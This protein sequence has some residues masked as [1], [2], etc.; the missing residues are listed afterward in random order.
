MMIMW[1][2]N[3]Q[4]PIQMYP[5][6]LMPLM[7]CTAYSFLYALHIIPKNH[8]CD[9]HYVLHIIYRINGIPSS[10]RLQISY[11]HPSKPAPTQE[12]PSKLYDHTTSS[13]I[14]PRVWKWT[15]TTNIGLCCCGDGMMFMIDRQWWRDRRHRSDCACLDFFYNQPACTC[16]EHTCNVSSTLLL[17]FILFAND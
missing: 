8:L 10:K 5:V 11:V 2:T 13:L 9:S 12:W 17:Y 7:H 14:S 1:T 6:Q 4:L 16:F 3:S 15:P